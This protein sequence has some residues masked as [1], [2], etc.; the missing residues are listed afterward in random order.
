MDYGSRYFGPLARI[1]RIFSLS[2]ML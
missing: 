2:M 1:L